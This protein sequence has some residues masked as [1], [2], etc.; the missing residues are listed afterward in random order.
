MSIQINKPVLLED[1]EYKASKHLQTDKEWNWMNPEKGQFEHPG[2]YYE[3]SLADWHTFD[4]LNADIDCDVLVIGGGLLGASTALHLAEQGVNTVLVEKNRIG[5]AASGRNGGQ[6]TPGLARWEAE[7]MIS[8]FSHED[9]KRLWHFTSTEAMQLIDDLLQRYGIEAD[10][11]HG[12][13][14][15]A[16][17]EGH[18]VTLTQGADARKYLAEIRQIRK[19]FWWPDRYARWPHPSFGPQPWTDLWLLL[20]WW[21]SL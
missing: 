19:L 12:H 18:L 20:T 3:C 6:L 11:K 15:A 4:A 1:V 2:N 21:S 16:V 10:R 9:A 17:H 8:Q 14:T 13:I 7:E 5:S